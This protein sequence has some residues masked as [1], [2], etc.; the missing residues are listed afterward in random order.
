MGSKSEELNLS[1]YLPGYPAES[2]HCSMQ[3]ACAKGHVRTSAGPSLAI[4]RRLLP[5]LAQRLLLI[6]RPTK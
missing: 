2:G 3:L 1:K 6:L 4:K 5:M